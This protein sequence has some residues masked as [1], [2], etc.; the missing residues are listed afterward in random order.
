MECPAESSAAIILVFLP[1]CHWVY[2]L[3]TSL[4]ISAEFRRDRAV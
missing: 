4:F 1:S 2:D 3:V